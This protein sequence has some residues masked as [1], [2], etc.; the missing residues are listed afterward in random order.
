MQQTHSESIKSAT[1]KEEQSTKFGNLFKSSA[2]NGNGDHPTSR[3]VKRV[4]PP[5]PAL[6]PE[7]A[8]EDVTPFFSFTDALESLTPQIPEWAT[9]DPFPQTTHYT[10]LRSV[11]RKR[12]FS[13][14]ECVQRLFW[15]EKEEAQPVDDQEPIRESSKPTTMAPHN[16]FPMPSHVELRCVRTCVHGI[17][18][19]PRFTEYGAAA[20]WDLCV[21]ADF[22][23]VLRRINQTVLVPTGLAFRIPVGHYGVIYGTDTTSVRKRLTLDPVMLDHTTKIHEV[24][25][26]VRHAQ[27][28]LTTLSGGDVLFTL[29]LHKYAS[30]SL[31]MEKGAYDEL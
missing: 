13:L 29:V 18:P 17:L 11:P 16:L 15:Q 2:A 6:S 12:K 10:D 28:G 7:S 31:C 22:K 23:F 19:T 26:W 25:V 5:S 14:R 3:V 8:P 27:P 24:Q 21:R 1:T 30:A 9:E 4:V 20:G